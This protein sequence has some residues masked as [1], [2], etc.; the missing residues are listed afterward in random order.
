MKLETFQL[1]IGHM[2]R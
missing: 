1:E 2:F